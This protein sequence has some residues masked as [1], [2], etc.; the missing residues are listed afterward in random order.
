[1]G[2]ACLFATFPPDFGLGGD[3]QSSSA[4]GFSKKVVFL[5]IK[6]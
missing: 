6:L 3:L 5:L 2:F 1:M 4:C